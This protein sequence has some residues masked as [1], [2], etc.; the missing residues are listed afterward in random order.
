RLWLQ[1]AIDRAKDDG[2]ARHVDN[3]APAGQ[4]GD[5]LVLLSPS[6]CGGQKHSANEQQPSHRLPFDGRPAPA[7]P[8]ILR[9]PVERSSKPG[10]L[11]I[12]VYR[13]A[14]LPVR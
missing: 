11:R 7:A 2:V 5:N 6:G 1:R 13:S 12:S 10:R 14:F 8:S 9:S 3:D 4:V